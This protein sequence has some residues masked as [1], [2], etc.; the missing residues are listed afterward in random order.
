MNSEKVDIFS[1]L[2]QKFQR[3]MTMTIA[4]VY[5]KNPELFYES[6]YL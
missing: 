5:D 3:L 2:I 4:V 1:S 6:Y